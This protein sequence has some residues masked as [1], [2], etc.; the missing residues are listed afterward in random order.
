M[1]KTHSL[2]HKLARAAC[3][4]ILAGLAGTPA[5]A[6]DNTDLAA[7]PDAARQAAVDGL[8]TFRKL[9]DFS[10][11][12]LE[13]K[14]CMQTYFIGADSVRG[15]NGQVPA[16]LLHN[17]GVTCA[18]AID[19]TLSGTERVVERDGA[20]ARTTLSASGYRSDVGE[21]RA[22]FADA[23]KGGQD[24]FTIYIPAL[25]YEF[26][27]RQTDQGLLLKYTMD[28]EDLGRQTGDVEKAE[29][30]LRRLKPIA[31]QLDLSAPG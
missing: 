5:L 19:G 25:H 29:D 28:D 15:Y 10:S 24:V 26:L 9:T 30:I 16:T 20:W 13:I 18:V 21:L 8:D 1:V 31:L 12:T 11:S 23:S 14:T 27:A 6:Q 2:K 17:Q 4:P 22:E 3:L 7:I